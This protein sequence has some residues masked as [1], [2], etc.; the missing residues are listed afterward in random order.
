MSIEDVSASSSSSE[1]SPGRIE[2]IADLLVNDNSETTD[3]DESEG[4]SDESTLEDEESNEDE[5]DELD[6]SGEADELE[7]SEE[8]D[9]TWGSALG[10]NDDQVVL[11]N[12]G[13]LTGINVKVDGSSSA[14]S[15]KDLVAGYQTNKHNTVKSQT[16]AEERKKFDES[17][18]GVEQ[19]YK[20]KIESAVSMAKILESRLISEFDNIDWK[21]LRETDPAEYAAAKQDYAARA[22]EIQSAQQ[23]LSKEQHDDQQALN[24][25]HLE[26]RDKY[27]REQQ[28]ILLSKNPSWNSPEVFNADMK[29]LKSF[30]SNQYGFTDADF[31]AVNDARVV[32]ML[33]DAR[34][35]R[36]GKKKTLEKLKKAPVAKFQRSTGHKAPKVTRLDKLTKAAKKS[37]GGNKRTLQADAVAE[38]LLSGG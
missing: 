34:A 32:E 3:L 6:E 31:D 11:D 9:D 35:F 26:D 28:Q 33:K 17:I 20:E 36:S 1:E 4:Q 21:E 7:E 37:R 10:L 22:Q 27:L 14:V 23:A 30:L 2:E 16:L 18:K 8:S 5:S 38:L 19:H 13:N 12:E 25:K 15:L 29:E 24:K